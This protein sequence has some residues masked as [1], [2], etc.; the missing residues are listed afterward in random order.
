MAE[1]I[2]L[3]SG[4]L[5]LTVFAFKSSSTLYETIKSF[6][7]HP[8][9]TRD[10]V[11]DAKADLE[12]RL[13]SIKEKLQLIIGKTVPESG[14][15]ASELQRIKEERASTE[16]CLQ[17]C[18]QLSNHIDQIQ[19]TPK[20]S[21]S[22]PGS[23]DPET[24]PE[25][26]ANEGLQ[27]CKNSL[28]LTIAKL[29]RHMQDVMDRLLTKSKTSMVSQEEFTN[30]ARLR[31]EWETAHK[32]IDIC[33]RADINL[34]ENISI[35]ENHA[36]G[37][38]VQF[39]VSTSGKVIHG[40]NRGL[41]WRSRQVGGYLSDSSVQ[42]LS[43]DMTSI[44]I[45]NTQNQDSSSPGNISSVPDDD[46]VNEPTS[47]FSERSEDVTEIPKSK[48]SALGE[49]DES[50]ML[51][52][53][54]SHLKAL[55]S[56]HHSKTW[57]LF[58]KVCPSSPEI[59]KSSRSIGWSVHCKSSERIRNGSHS[60][61]ELL[62]ESMRVAQ[63]GLPAYY[64]FLDPISYILDSLFFRQDLMMRADGRTPATKQRKRS[65]S[66]QDQ[67]NLR[68]KQ[69]RRRMGLFRKCVEFSDKYGAQVFILIHV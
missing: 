36:T 33:S 61:M 41:G 27:D 23:I 45:Q 25:R 35:I 22:S 21:G 37:D 68:Q 51:D 17:I 10:L 18:A 54:H 59:Q 15:D 50:S 24:L 56:V 34:K 66:Q 69:R 7:S 38:A 47:E 14:L 31:D 62:Q 2:S 40:K 63:T 5:T 53:N 12:A 9:T 67:S 3:A 19:L 4:L 20:G 55:K 57:P 48:F 26:V 65:R 8:K 30:L 44:N 42:Q 13:D 58:Q 43:R 49:N 28:I 32:C 6:Q 52:F 39:M 1:P 16:K 64:K 46:L 11:K 60:G 29:E